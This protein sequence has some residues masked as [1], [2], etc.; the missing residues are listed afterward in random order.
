MPPTI[1][2]EGQTNKRQTNKIALASSRGL[3]R[4]DHAGIAIAGAAGVATILVVTLWHYCIAAF[5]AITVADFAALA[6]LMIVAYYT[7]ETKKLREVSAESARIAESARLETFRPIVTAIPSRQVRLV[8]IG[9]GPAMNPLII[10]WDGNIAE[11]P[12]EADFPVLMQVHVEYQFVQTWTKMD[13]AVLCVKFPD[14]ADIIR[15]FTVPNAARFLVVYRDL[16]NSMLYSYLD[17]YRENENNNREKGFWAMSF[18]HGR[19]T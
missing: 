11:T 9:N 17:D 16:A 15:E 18:R 10:F 1:P 12:A 5:A 4:R 19:V 6:M 3:A 13:V 2:Q 7:Y 8:N 14:Y